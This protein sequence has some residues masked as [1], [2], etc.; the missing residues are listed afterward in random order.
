MAVQQREIVEVCYPLPN[1]KLKPHPVIVISNE[2]IFDTEGIFYGVMLSTKDFNSDYIFEITDDMLTK[3][4]K[5]DESYVKCQLIQAFNEN[6]ITGR[7][8]YIK[9]EPFEKL[10]QKIIESIF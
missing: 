3:A 7:Y 2:D 9:K 1:G 6:E 8:G 4:K 10:K 5:R